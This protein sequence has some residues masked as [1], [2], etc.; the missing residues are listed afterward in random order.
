LSKRTNLRGSTIS[1][2]SIRQDGTCRAH[3]GSVENY[4][5]RSGHDGCV[6]V[7]Q[8]YV[9]CVRSGENTFG[10]RLLYSG[11]EWTLCL[12]SHDSSNQDDDERRF[13]AN[14]GT[15]ARHR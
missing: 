7:K 10:A 11:L 14:V 4:F 8:R 13:H 1:A 2:S 3:L 15:G 12:S 9:M 5:R 6:E